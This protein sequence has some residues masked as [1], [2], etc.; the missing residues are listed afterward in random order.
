MPRI[1]EFNGIIIRMYAGD[2]NPPHVHVEYQ[3]VEALVGINPAAQLRGNLP[4][5]QLAV[6]LAWI[7]EN[8]EMLLSKW[9]ELNG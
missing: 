5:R 9:D 3:H 8:Q 2:H 4:G 7:E 1:A 6:V